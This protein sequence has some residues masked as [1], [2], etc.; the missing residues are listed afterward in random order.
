MK[1]FVDTCAFCAAAIPS[2]NLN[3]KAKEIFIHIKNHSRIYTSNFVLDE[4]YTLLNARAD[5]RQA[6]LFMDIFA[7]SG[8]N[9]LRV[10]ESI[11]NDAAMIFRKHD[12]PRLSFTDCTSF[13]LINAHRLDHVYSF[14]SHFS[15]FR[16][17]L[18]VK[19]L[20]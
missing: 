19:V 15:F 1:V 14:D 3:A 6:V 4:L 9:L 2:D 8:I 5:H 12:F 11:E 10:T 20:G 13:A 16:F 7:K 17:D 18:P